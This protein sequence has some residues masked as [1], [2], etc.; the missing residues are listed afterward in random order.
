MCASTAADTGLIC[1]TK[2]ENRKGES[3]AT[4]EVIASS[5]DREVQRGKEKG[6]NL[7]CRRSHYSLIDMSP[8]GNG[9][10]GE[11]EDHIVRK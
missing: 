2:R 4:G 1:T 8:R 5:C 3:E 7:K 10:S 6:L 9:E 11:G